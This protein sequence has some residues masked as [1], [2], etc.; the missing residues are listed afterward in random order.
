MNEWR[1]EDG[2]W[3][4][5]IRFEGDVPHQD[6]EFVI[7]A[8][9]HGQLVNCLPKTIGSIKLTW[10]EHP[11]I[12]LLDIEFMERHHNDPRTYD[13]QTGKGAASGQIYTIKINNDKVE[14]HLIRTWMA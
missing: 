9:R 6:A 8:I 3:Q 2:Q 12:D 5:Y 14:L 11:V 1:I 7:R 13:L 10:D 4:M